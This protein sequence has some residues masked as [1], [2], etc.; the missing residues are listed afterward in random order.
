MPRFSTI[1]IFCEFFCEISGTWS[2]MLLPN[3]QPQGALK[4]WKTALW[5]WIYR[6]TV[7]RTSLMLGTLPHFNWLLRE[8]SAVVFPTETGILRASLPLEDGRLHAQVV[9]QCLTPAPPFIFLCAGWT[10]GF[11]GLLW[12]NCEIYTQAEKNPRIALQNCAAY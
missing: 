8:H 5:F 4:S 2:Q 6:I 12:Q 3:L 9:S 10:E 11:H 1:K 7:L